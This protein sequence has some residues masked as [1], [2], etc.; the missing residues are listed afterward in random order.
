MC[1]ICVLINGMDDFTGNIYILHTLHCTG[2]Y[3]S[4]CAVS[5]GLFHWLS[6]VEAYLYY[7]FQIVSLP[8]AHK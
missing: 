6:S 2:H 3:Y 1:S 7:M 4:E 5:N 8:H